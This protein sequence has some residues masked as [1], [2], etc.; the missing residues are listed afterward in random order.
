ML[1]AQGAGDPAR[2][3]AAL[4]DDRNEPGGIEKR[5]HPRSPILLKV[6]YRHAGAFL[7]DYTENISA[8]GVFI[9]TDLHIPQGT[10]LHF[11]VSFPGLLDPI[12]LTGVVMWCR[13][14]PTPDEPAG[15]GVR[16]QPETGERSAPLASL[17]EQLD[18]KA[19]GGDASVTGVFRVMLVE[20]NVVVRDM[21][22]YA[23]R[24]LSQRNRLPGV[25]LDV[26]EASDGKQAWE[27]LC[28]KPFHLLVLDLYMPIMDGEQL[29]RQGRSD[30]RMQS[31]PVIVVSS[32]GNEDS[33]RVLRAGADIFLPKPIK[34]KDMVET[35]EALVLSGHLPPEPSP[36]NEPPSGG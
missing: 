17:V 4:A 20:D 13:S 14:Q 11:E 19:P 6:R 21:F 25:V 35:I 26:C 22:R 31:I 18:G 30:A 5:K 29:L 23:I 16:F 3:G 2:R 34:L 8:G 33:V 32:G 15:I 10:V 28:K 24:K 7:A 36:G 12:A 1:P 9:A 27:L